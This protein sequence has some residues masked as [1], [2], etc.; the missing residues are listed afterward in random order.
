[1][2]ILTIYGTVDYNTL[3]DFDLSKKTM[4]Y[5]ESQKVGADIFFA[6]EIDLT[7]IDDE[8]NE[9]IKELAEVV[10]ADQKYTNPERAF[11]ISEYTNV[12]FVDIEESPFDENRY[13]V[14]GDEYLVLT[15][16][17]ADELALTQARDL[18]DD[19]GI[20]NLGTAAQEYIYSNLVDVEW[21]ND[22]MKEYHESYANDIHDEN[23]SDT[24]LYVS[25]LHEEMVEKG[26]M[27]APEWPEDDDFE[28]EREDFDEKEPDADEFESDDEYSDAYDIWEAA[29]KE[30]ETEQD[31]KEDSATNDLIDAK[32][33][34]GNKLS[35][36]VEDK[37]DEFV[38]ELNSNYENGLE[39]YNINFGEEEIAIIA[40]EQNLVDFDDV[41][42]YIVEID[43]RA[44]TLTSGDSSEDSITTKYKGETFEFYIFKLDS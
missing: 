1:M 18:L 26:I 11:A 40:K 36:E 27:A 31:E 43:G 12:S 4:D 15:D 20:A 2:N 14:D 16:E 9:E 21:F 24:D 17:E 3:S 39:Y 10:I 7:E 8:F 19:L 22:A 28:Y 23:A 42:K 32:E 44:Y 37:I 13:E 38:E 35:D 6:T 41:A 30:W 5:I 33:S 25:R 34:Y 29:E